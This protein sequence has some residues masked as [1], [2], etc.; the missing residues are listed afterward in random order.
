MPPF[1]LGT[2]GSPLALVQA[3][4]VRDALIA[5]HGWE[6]G[7]V[8][9]VTIRTT[10]DAVQDRPLAEIGGKA[11]WTKEIDR[12][13]LANEID[14]SVHSMKDVETFR[15]ASIAIAAM[16]PRADVRDRLIGADSVA[17]LKQGAVVGTSSPRRAAQ[18]R[19]LRPDLNIVM[20]RGNVDTRLGKVAAGEADATLLAAAGLERLGRDMGTAI[21]ADTMLPAPAQG[22]VGIEARAGDHDARRWLAAIDHGE[23]HACVTAERALLAALKADCHS[24]VGALATIEGAILTL[25]A[26]LLSE[27]GA[28]SVHAQE[29]GAPGDVELPRAVARDLLER[30]PPEVRQL[31]DG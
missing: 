3:H 7:R 27:D 19:K 25:R 10:G 28:Q 1:R 14:A 6:P 20:F 2:R 9:I 8:E 13:L 16:L 18:L 5:A 22:A 12:A 17:A 11:L 24:P 4:M 15:P 21:P 26:E 30:A 23:T 31:F 29:A